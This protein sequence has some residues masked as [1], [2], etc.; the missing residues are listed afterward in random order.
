V[1]F[2][3]SGEYTL[4]VVASNGIQSATS[5]VQVTT[6][7]QPSVTHATTQVSGVQTVGDANSITGFVV[8]FN[9]P[10]DPTTAQNVLGYRILQQSSVGKKLH[11]AQWLFGINPGDQIETSAQKIASAVYDSQSDSV[12]LTLAAPMSVKNGVR[13]VEVMGAGPH[14]VLDSNGK[15]IDG[16]ANGKAGSNFTYKLNVSVGKS[17]TYQTAEGDKVKLSLSGPGQIVSLLPT[18]T[19]TPVIDLI[20][21]DSS[22]SI[23]TGE[24]RKGR[25]SPG[26]AVLDE[27]NGTADADIQL[28]EEFHVNQI[29]GAA[30]V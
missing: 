12:S 10:L 4:Q 14:A 18:G 16:D 13:V 19:K 30:A 24:L 9:G 22:T 2:L 15:P 7:V 21:T 6:T 23:L 17:V 27:L 5:Q 29:T 8:T 26:Y 1:T 20:D 3:E 25:K 11:F 28:G